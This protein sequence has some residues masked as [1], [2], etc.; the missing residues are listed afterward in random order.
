MKRVL[1]IILTF[2]VPLLLGV[3]LFRFILLRD[4]YVFYGTSDMVDMMQTFPISS[5]DVLY[6]IRTDF[7]NIIGGNLF[8]I[9]FLLVDIFRFIAWP[10]EMAFNLIV[11]VFDFLA[12]I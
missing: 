6:S 2:S 7:N 4:N 11:W 1:L 8:D 5:L 9:P 12:L 10:F 3:N